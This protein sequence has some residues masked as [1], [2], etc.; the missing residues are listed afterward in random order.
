MSANAG[1]DIYNRVIV[2]GAAAT[3]EPMIVERSAA[4]GPGVVGEPVTSPAPDNP[5]FATN[6]ASWTPSTGTT[7]TRDTGVFD[8]SPA[9][10]YWERPAAPLQM[11]AKGDTLTET[12]TGTFEAGVMY[13]LTAKLGRLVAL[14]SSL[15]VQFGVDADYGQA[16]WSAGLSYEMQTVAWTPSADTS[17]VTLTLMANGATRW[18]I[19][20][21]ALTV[22]KPTLVDR[23]GFRRTHILP[24]KASLTTELAT[25]VA[26]V[27]LDA[28]KTTPFKGTATITGDSAA[29]HIT[30]G[31]GV[32]PEQLLLHTGELL[33]L[34]DR[35]DPDTGGQGR[36]GRIAEVTYVSATDTATITLD[37]SRASHEA[38]LQRL[39]VVV[40]GA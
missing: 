12:F 22:A 35:I 26:T 13:M 34:A 37:S 4:Q 18:S 5:S 36:D 1:E 25:Q 23:R 33:R 39:A 15:T 11:L 32:P 24:V 30:T 8:T 7:I 29:R 38:L 21:L 40:G 14:E 9:S 27:W 19:D 3:G 16:T 10:A 28:H 20:S 2:Q 6:T 17:G 31:A